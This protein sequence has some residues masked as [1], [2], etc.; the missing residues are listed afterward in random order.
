MDYCGKLSNS[1][2]EETWGGAHHDFARTKTCP[3]FPQIVS[4]YP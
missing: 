2:L 3:F 4:F 1:A